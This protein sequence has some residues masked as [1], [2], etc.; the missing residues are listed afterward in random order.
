LSILHTP[1]DSRVAIVCRAFSVHRQ[2]TPHWGGGT[3]RTNYNSSVTSHVTPRGPTSD[4]TRSLRVGAGRAAKVRRE[5][6]REHRHPTQTLTWSAPPTP[7]P[8]PAG[9]PPRQAGLTK[10]GTAPNTLR[11]ERSGSAP[12]SAVRAHTHVETSRQ[13]SR[14][15]AAGADWPSWRHL[16]SSRTIDVRSRQP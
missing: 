8:G 16:I 6:R 2:Y 14:G 13:P 5:P 15:A 3:S 7:R 1:Y 10:F 9:S 12:Y 11:N 4:T